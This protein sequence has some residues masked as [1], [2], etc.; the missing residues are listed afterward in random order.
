MAAGAALVLTMVLFMINASL[1]VR[2]AR[3]QAALRRQVRGE[4]SSTMGNTSSRPA[5]MVAVSR[6][7]ENGE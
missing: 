6:S 7:L 3:R 1:R 5:S 2:A 4:S